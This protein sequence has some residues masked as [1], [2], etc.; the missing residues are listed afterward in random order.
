MGATGSQSDLLR[1]DRAWI[2]DACWR[3]ATS[4][5]TRQPQDR[6]A[7]LSRPVLHDPVDV[8]DLPVRERAFGTLKYERLYREDVTDGPWLAEHADDFRIEFN[9][10]R[11]HEALCWNRPREVHLGLADPM[12]PN[13]PE[14]E[15]LPA[16]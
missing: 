12:T 10:V 6:N 11:P 5:R 9:A 3:S 16:P 1:T 4:R 2:S 7:Y 13:F 15:T 14:P 8:V